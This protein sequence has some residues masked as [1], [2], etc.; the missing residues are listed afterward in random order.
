MA[1]CLDCGN[2]IDGARPDQEFCSGPCRAHYY[3]TRGATGA[4]AGKHDTQFG[5]CEWCGTP[6]G[7]NAYADRGGKRQK[8][9][10]DDTCRQKA[11]RAKKRAERNAGTNN[12]NRKSHNGQQTKREETGSKQKQNTDWWRSA[13]WWVVL[14]VSKNEM[15]FNA[16][17]KRYRVLVKHY[18]PDVCKLPNATEIMQCVNA[19]YDKAKQW[20][21]KR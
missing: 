17:S 11:H 6:F 2:E 8:R 5:F 13:D 12:T 15:D 3:R 4:H 14:G 10:C 9:F 21:G 19:A 18:H 20:H 16:I 1:I 7:F